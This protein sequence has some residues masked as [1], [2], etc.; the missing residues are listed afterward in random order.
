M[1]LLFASDEI[2]I[3]K[4]IK[5][6]N[7]TLADLDFDPI[8][9]A[10]A[11]GDGNVREICK[12]ILED[13]NTDHGTVE[14]RQ[15][16][17]KDAMSNSGQ[18]REIAKI[19][20]DTVKAIKER[21]FW[22]GSGTPSIEIFESRRVLSIFM[23]SLAKIIQQLKSIENGKSSEIFKKYADEFM[24][25]F[26]E[27]W[28]KDVREIIDITDFSDSLAASIGLG[29]DLSFENI[30]LLKSGKKNRLI[31]FGTK[32]R[33]VILPPNCESCAEELRSF[34]D[35]ITSEV[36][37]ILK[38]AASFVYQKILLMSREFS[39]YVGCVNFINSMNRVG[40]K[41]TFP[42]ITDGKLPEI[43]FTDLV[44]ASLALR[45]GKP[46]VPNSL[47]SPGA[48]TF[49]VTGPNSGGKS[50]F[51]RSVGQA[52]ILAQSGL[53][54]PAARYRCTM[55]NRVFAYFSK[56]EK[57]GDQKGRFEKE[58][59]DLQEI[60]SN[61]T[62]SD[63]VIL[64]EPLASTNQYDGAMIMREVIGSSE[65]GLIVTF[66]STHFHYLASWISESHSDRRVLMA[67]ERLADGQRTFRIRQI[68]AAQGTSWAA[69]VWKK[70]MAYN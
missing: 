6:K 61:L 38:E 32:T 14:L 55:F 12:S 16:I 47:G 28:I 18:F 25:T 57:Q 43:T 24:S 3:S 70:I 42:T 58:L 68:P 21:I 67:A 11:E 15:A 41:L 64:D 26:N 48:L 34:R 33:K 50:V 27:G 7:G 56:D 2:D 31:R 17:V 49:I 40:I 8:L 66:T 52:Q 1:N 13:L 9:D 63:L 45:S 23:A 37:V 35:A 54:V 46:P 59:S 29:W 65:E 36:A 22:M 44:E 19:A 69:D 53:P 60:V 4:P 20:S 62:G 5:H 39:F 51:L 10:M 30:V